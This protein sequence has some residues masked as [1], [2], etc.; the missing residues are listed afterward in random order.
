MMAD[1]LFLAGDELVIFGDVAG[2]GAAGDGGFD[3]NDTI[4]MGDK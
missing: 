3:T 4:A 1:A 2:Y